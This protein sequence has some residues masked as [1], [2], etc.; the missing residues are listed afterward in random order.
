MSQVDTILSSLYAVLNMTISVIVGFILAKINVLTPTTRKVI[1][2]VNYYALIPIYS[3]VFIMQAI[4]RDKLGEIFL[5]CASTLPCIIVGFILTFGTALIAGFDIRM[6]YSFTFINTYGNLVVMPQMLANTFCEKNERY[7]HT[8]QCREGL[9]NAYTSVPMIF[10]NIIYWASVLPVLQNEKRISLE[11]KKVFLTVLNYYKSI[12]EFL[13]D[14]KFERAKLVF[15]PKE[16][17]PSDENNEEPKESGRGKTASAL[18]IPGQGMNTELST[19]PDEWVTPENLIFIRE[20]Y[21]RNITGKDYHRIM[22]R[23]SKFEGA[24]YNTPENMANKESIEKL[25]II[26][27]G[28]NKTPP[29]ESLLSF[30]F[31]K[32]RIF[33]APPTVC[34]LLGLALGFIFPFKEWVF[35]PLNKPLPTFIGS[36]KNIGTMM[37]PVSMFMLGTYLAQSATISPTMFI[38]WKHVIISNVI[39][40]LILP[41]IGLVWVLYV[42]R[43]LNEQVYASNPI[44]VFID[45][46]QWIVPN[47]LVLIAVYVVA[48]YF[49]REFAVLSIYMNL[50]AIPAMAFFMVIY[51]NLYEASLPVGQLTV[52]KPFLIIHVYYCTYYYSNHILILQIQMEAKKAYEEEYNDIADE[53]FEYTLPK[54]VEDDPIS[55]D[56]KYLVYKRTI[57]EIYRIMSQLEDHCTS[58]AFLEPINEFIA[59]TASKIKEIPSGKEHPHEYYQYF[60]QYTKLIDS[61]LECNYNIQIQIQRS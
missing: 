18:V 60:L 50:V 15:S 46:T 14:T 38:R 2:D 41:A 43:V 20:Y 45:Y 28:L 37:S 21:D 31:Y 16:K 10:I 56:I 57:Q 47:G 61:L 39:K 53:D 54:G 17:L 9:V 29:K 8:S 36:L 26:P 1:S 55:S 6:R 34:S 30:E 48:D 19:S 11:I 44:L 49:A 12:D 51:F 52:C 7:G 25:V 4:D 13:N 33:T 59:R 42:I 27:E 40:N 3:L 5:L 35:N 23:F 24:V 32:K 58:P 22:E